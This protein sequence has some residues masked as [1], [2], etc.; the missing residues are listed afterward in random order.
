[1]WKEYTTSL[2][3]VWLGNLYKSVFCCAIVLTKCRSMNAMSMHRISIMEDELTAGSM[4]DLAR[5]EAF[6]EDG[7]SRKAGIR[8][9]E[10]K[11]RFRKI[12]SFEQSRT[13]ECARHACCLGYHMLHIPLNATP[14]AQASLCMIPSVQAVPRPILSPKPSAPPSRGRTTT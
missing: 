4:H 7:L 9:T 6:W 5:Y 14:N 13:K 2:G 12:V 3:R 10:R 11:A 8:L 1:M